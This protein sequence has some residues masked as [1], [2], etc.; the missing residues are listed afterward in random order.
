MQCDANSEPELP[1]SIG[2]IELENKHNEAS[3]SIFVEVS[4]DI[5]VGP[6]LAIASNIPEVENE[7]EL[8]PTFLP[9]VADKTLV[10]SLSNLP[11]EDEEEGMEE[12][13][14]TDAQL[15]WADKGKAKMEEDIKAQNEAETPDKIVKEITDILEA[16]RVH[17]FPKLLPDGWGEM[18]HVQRCTAIANGRRLLGKC[19][20]DLHGAVSRVSE[21]EYAC[22]NLVNQVRLQR[23]VSCPSG[24]DVGIKRAHI[25]SHFHHCAWE[26]EWRLDSG[27]RVVDWRD[28]PP[29]DRRAT[30]FE[31]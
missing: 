16:K 29:R 2:V 17:Y 31:S 26:H 24:C 3:S 28:F 4:A 30:N 8:G 10:K 11:A 27:M 23:K 20:G 1:I 21:F 13:E 12:P 19:E 22:A 18:N 6:E 25:G 9:V 15:S 7:P 5:Q 14:A